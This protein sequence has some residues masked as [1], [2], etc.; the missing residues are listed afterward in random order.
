M[1]SF[2]CFPIYT[3]KPLIEK[4][5]KHAAELSKFLVIKLASHLMP[6]RLARHAADL[7]DSPAPHWMDG[8]V[9]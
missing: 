5:S 6:G 8:W 1:I 7:T 4:P 3:I 9:H 2:L